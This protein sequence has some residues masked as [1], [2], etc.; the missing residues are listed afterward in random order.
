MIKLK[1]FFIENKT[2]YRLFFSPSIDI[3]VVQLV[4]THEL[5]NG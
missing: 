3:A 1:C 4:T 5:L 2:G